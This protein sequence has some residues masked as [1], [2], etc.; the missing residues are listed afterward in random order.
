[1]SVNIQIERKGNFKIYSTRQKASDKLHFLLITPIDMMSA[2]DI[3]VLVLDF[4]IARCMP[5]IFVPY[6]ILTRHANL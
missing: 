2:S 1:M 3:C 5:R 6:R 4:Q